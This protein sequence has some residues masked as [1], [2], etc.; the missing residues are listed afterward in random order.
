MNARMPT[1]EGVIR[2][3]IRGGLILG[4]LFA[5]FCL[6]LLPWHGRALLVRPD[7]LLLMLIYWCMHEP[8][9]VGAASAFV[10]GLIMDVAESAILGQNALTYSLAA[11]LAIS[12]RLRVLRFGFWAQALHVAA[13]LLLVQLLQLLENFLIGV[14]LPSWLYLGRSLLEALLWPFISWLLEL[15]RLQP[16]REEISG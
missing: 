16:R 6:N 2:N 8:R 5:G 3:P 9:S 15:Y 11:Y 7:L 4:T 10:G 14:P 1:P 12:M 13:V